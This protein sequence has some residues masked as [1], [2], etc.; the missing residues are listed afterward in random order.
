MLQG[1]IPFLMHSHMTV[2]GGIEDES[3]DTFDKKDEKGA[4]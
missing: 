2:I 1:V 4:P 3:D